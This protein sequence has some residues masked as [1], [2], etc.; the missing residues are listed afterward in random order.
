MALTRCPTGGLP[1]TQS[2]GTQRLSGQQQPSRLITQLRRSEQRLD[3]GAATCPRRAGPLGRR[4]LVLP[5]AW[6]LLPQ[7]PPPQQP[8]KSSFSVLGNKGM[9]S[10]SQQHSE[11]VQD[12]LWY[13]KEPAVAA[14]AKA[15]RSDVRLVNEFNTYLTTRRIELQVRGGGAQRGC[16]GGG[17]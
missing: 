9:Q 6:S 15:T 11:L 7:P 3:S 5:A 14:C 16:L 1:A 2:A 13:G 4:Q 12:P 17:G 10:F 8:Q